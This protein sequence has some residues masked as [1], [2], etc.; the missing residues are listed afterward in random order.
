M[1]PVLFALTSAVCALALTACGSS[2]STESTSADGVPLVTAG[3]LTICTDVPYEPFDY[4]VDDE[5]TGFDL[6]L[7]REVATDMGL[8]MEVKDIGFD[9]IQSGAALNA[10]QCDVAAGA[11]TI[12]AA[13]AALSLFSLSSTSGQ[14]Q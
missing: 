8:E 5:F 9:G 2:A 11:I 3:T 14:T 12:T 7:M 6:D 10:S 1:R 4:V 13:A